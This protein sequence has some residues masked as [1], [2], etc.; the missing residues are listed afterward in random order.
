MNKISKLLLCSLLCTVFI[1]SNCQ[2]QLH[3][4]LGPAIGYTIPSGD[5]GGATADY[6][7]GTKYGMSGGIDFG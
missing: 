4:S 7:K 3:I 5:F 6:Y 1:I 2:A